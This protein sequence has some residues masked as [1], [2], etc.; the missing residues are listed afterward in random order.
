V[1][2]VS[3]AVAVVGMAE[4]IQLRGGHT[5]TD[6]RLGRLPELDERSRRFSVGDVLDKGKPVV[7]KSW[8]LKIW[9]D[10]A[11]TSACTGFSRAYDLAAVPAPLKKVDGTPFDFDFAHALYK[12]AQ[13]Y[14]EWTG[15]DYEG[16]SVLGACKA[17]KVLGYVGEYR[18]A[19]SHQDLLLA[20]SY[21]GP[22]VL[23]TDWYQSMFDPKANGLIFPDFQSGFAGG[24]AYI[25]NS[26]KV[27]RTAKRRWLGPDEEIRDEPLILGRNSWGREWGKDGHWCMWSTD[28]E[29]LLRADKHGGRY[30]GEA[31]VVLTPFKRKT[32]E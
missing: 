5:A 28:L 11:N 8:S 12:L 24:H 29:R 13:Q 30:P 4:V 14:D 10:Q 9:L 26:I 6:P 23:G 20:L 19:F 2:Q 15:E 17:L 1:S 18:W 16:S 25:A 31:S 7:S 27:T 32:K 22:V 21:K 3:A